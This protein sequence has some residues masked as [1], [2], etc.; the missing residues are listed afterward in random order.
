[1]EM[2]ILMTTIVI[3]LGMAMYTTVQVNRLRDATVEALLLIA[4]KI[5]N[6][7]LKEENE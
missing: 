2:K 5:K 7:E 4:M 6:G 1:M 3:V